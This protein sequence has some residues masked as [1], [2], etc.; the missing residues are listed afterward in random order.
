MRY[1]PPFSSLNARISVT[2]DAGQ[3]WV[4]MT[5]EE[6]QGVIRKLLQAIDVDEEWYQRRYP[7]VE[8]AISDGTIKSAREHFIVSG[9]FEGRQ[10]SESQPSSHEL[11]LNAPTPMARPIQQ[12]EATKKDLMLHIGHGKTGTS[13][14]QSILVLNKAKLEDHGV[15]Y[16]EHVSD[17]NALTGKITSG[18]GELILEG[19]YVLQSDKNYLFSNENLFNTLLSNNTLE[20]VAIHRGFNLRVF[21]Y[22]RNVFEVL[23]SGWG[24]WVKRGGSVKDLDAFLLDDTSNMPFAKVKAWLDLAEKHGFELVVRNYSNYKSNIADIFLGDVLRSKV[25]DFDIK[26][27]AAA[28]INRSLTHAEYEIQ[29]AFNRNMADSSRF[30]SDALVDGC[31]DVKA[32]KLKCKSATYDTI[33]ERISPL[34]DEINARISPAER[35]KIE[36]REAVVDDGDAREYSLSPSQIEVVVRSICKEIERRLFDGDANY[37]RDIADKIVG[38]KELR[39][40]DAL[41]LMKL[42]KRARP[43]GEYISKRVDE[44]N[45]ELEHK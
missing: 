21:L 40:A 29:R 44:W 7:D 5:Y 20:R 37:L 45:S 16:P 23:F 3:R 27:P 33:V 18:N 39:L 41:D 4:R 28:T 25:L 11:N 2:E 43:G 10:A 32:S 13:F 36:P 24:Q 31:P 30:V 9:Y 38:G 6:F 1:V 12:I 34:I 8:A 35:V 22:T 14:I 42:A 26:R 15:L 19:S 17:A